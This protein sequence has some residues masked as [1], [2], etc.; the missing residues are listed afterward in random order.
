MTEKEDRDT[1]RIGIEEKEE[2][3]YEVEDATIMVVG[4]RC[5]H[6]GE[7]PGKLVGVV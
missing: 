2:K 3:K 1:R 4:S 5:W 6:Q 7:A